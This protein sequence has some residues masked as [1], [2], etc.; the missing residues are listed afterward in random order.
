MKVKISFLAVALHTEHCYVQHPLLKVEDENYKLWNQLK[1][2]CV[3][4]GIEI[5]FNHFVI[6]GIDV[7]TKTSVFIGYNDGIVTLGFDIAYKNDSERKYFN[8]PLFSIVLL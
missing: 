4:N 2:F 8:N 3:D 6:Q 1:K 7:N 5:Y